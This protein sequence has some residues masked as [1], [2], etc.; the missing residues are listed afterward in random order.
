MHIT[1]KSQ[2]CLLKIEYL[3]M[4]CD[5]YSYLVT[6]SDTILLP[7]FYIYA[8]FAYVHHKMKQFRMND[9]NFLAAYKWPIVLLDLVCM[10]LMDLC[11]SHLCFVF[12]LELSIFSLMTIVC[13]DKKERHRLFSAFNAIICRCYAQRNLL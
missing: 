7:S 5:I 6:T 2:Q 9:G 8:P 12:H 13:R 1:S 4:K 10:T 11:I 3:A